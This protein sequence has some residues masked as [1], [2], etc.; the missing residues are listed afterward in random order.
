MVNKEGG[1]VWVP[2][3]LDGVDVGGGAT[4]HQAGGHYG[5]LLGVIVDKGFVGANEGVGIGQSEWNEI[6][7][8]SIKQWVVWPNL[9]GR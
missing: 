1:V 4:M 6:A 5:F 7:G 8:G 3:G 2:K 9:S